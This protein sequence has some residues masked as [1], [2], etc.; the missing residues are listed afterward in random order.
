VRRAIL[1]LSWFAVL[2]G[3]GHI[4]FVFPLEDFRLGHLWFIGSGIAIAFAGFIN[5]LGQATIQRKSSLLIVLLANIVMSFLFV[6]ATTVVQEPQI[7]FGIA[8]FS[9]LTVLTLLLIRALAHNV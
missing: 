7:Y 6:I 9:S 3:V 1:T 2:M 8:L 4:L 5:I